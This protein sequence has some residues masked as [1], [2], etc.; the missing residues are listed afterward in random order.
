MGISTNVIYEENTGR[1]LVLQAGKEWVVPAGYEL[2]QFRNGVEPVLVS[3]EKGAVYLKPNTF[4][5][6]DY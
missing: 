1:V 6:T 3:D 2:A 4:I 5:V